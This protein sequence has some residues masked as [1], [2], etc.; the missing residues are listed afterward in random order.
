MEAPRGKNW[1]VMWLTFSD[2]RSFLYHRQRPKT[3]GHPTLQKK[4]DRAK[5]PRPRQPAIESEPTDTWAPSPRMHPVGPP[6]TGRKYESKAMFTMQPEV[7]QM[8]FSARMRPVFD[9]F[10]TVRTQ[11]RFLQMWLRSLGYVVLNPIHIWSLQ[12]WRVSVWSGHIDTWQ[13]S[14]FCVLMRASRKK[15]SN[16][17]D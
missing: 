7:T 9:L 4:P 1:R 14:L 12:M 2:L 3:Q 6:A 15:N 5:G 8:W 13:M 10:I 17:G 11:I 16:H